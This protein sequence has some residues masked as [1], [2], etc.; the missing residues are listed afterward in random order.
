M[1][2]EEAKDSETHLILKV[3]VNYPYY[4]DVTI[5]YFN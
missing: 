3:S 5:Q 1:G 2:L 4:L